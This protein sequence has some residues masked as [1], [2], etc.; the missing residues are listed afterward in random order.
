[1]IN[2]LKEY[3]KKINKDIKNKLLLKINVEY[4]E[5]EILRFPFTF[6]LKCGIMVI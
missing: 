5:N 2:N 4:P 6:R 1:M 3:I